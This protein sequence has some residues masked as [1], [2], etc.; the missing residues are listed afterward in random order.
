MK[1]KPQKDIT[2]IQLFDRF[3]T[4]DKARKHLEGVLWK[5]GT[6]RFAKNS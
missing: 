5:D 2:L 1:T 6:D 4:D 3:A